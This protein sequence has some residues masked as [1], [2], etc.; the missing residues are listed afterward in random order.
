MKKFCFVLVFIAL[1]FSGFAG[2]CGEPEANFKFPNEERLDLAMKQ[3]GVSVTYKKS[4]DLFWVS[5][6]KNMMPILEFYGDIKKGANAILNGQS[7]YTIKMSLRKGDIE[8]AL[9]RFEKY[10]SPVEVDAFP[11]VLTSHQVVLNQERLFDYTSA[12]LAMPLESEVAHLKN[13]SKDELVKRSKAGD[14]QA[15]CACFLFMQSPSNSP[16]ESSDVV[17]ITRAILK[18][19]N[20]LL[21]MPFLKVIFMLYVTKDDSLLPEIIKGNE[22]CILNS[23]TSIDADFA[24]AV[25]FS[26]LQSGAPDELLKRYEAFFAELYSFE[27]IDVLEISSSILYSFNHDFIKKLGE[28]ARARKFIADILD[29]QISLSENPEYSKTQQYYIRDVMQPILLA[30]NMSDKMLELDK[31][32]KISKANLKALTL[33]FYKNRDKFMKNLSPDDEAFIEKRIPELR[34]EIVKLCEANDFDGVYILFLEYDRWKNAEFKKFILLEFVEL[35]KAMEAFEESKDEL[36]KDF[37]EE[38]NKKL[39]SKFSRDKII[40]RRLESSISHDLFFELLSKLDDKDTR[41]AL[42]S[43]LENKVDSCLKM[44]YAKGVSKDLLFSDLRSDSYMF[45]YAVYSCK[46]GCLLDKSDKKAVELIKSMNNY[47]SPFSDYFSMVY[48]VLNGD[49]T[50]P[51][52]EMRI[53]LEKNDEV[54]KLL[55]DEILAHTKSDIRDKV[56]ILLNRGDEKAAVKAL[57]GMRISRDSFDNYS[58]FRALKKLKKYMSREELLQAGEVFKRLKFK[59]DDDTKDKAE[60]LQNLIDVYHEDYALMFEFLQKNKEFFKPY[61]LEIMAAFA[62][63]GQ[64]TDKDEALSKSL[65]ERVNKEA[66]ADEIMYLLKRVYPEYKV[67]QSDNT[68]KSELMNLG[69][70][71]DSKSGEALYYFASE[72]AKDRKNPEKV[73]KAAELYLKAIDCSDFEESNS[74]YVYRYFALPE[75]CYDPKVAF[76]IASKLTERFDSEEMRE[77]LATHYLT[78]LGVEKDEKKA[79]EILKDIVRKNPGSMAAVVLAYCKEK[80]IAGESLKEGEKYELL[81]KVRD[82]NLSD[83]AHSFC[84]RESRLKNRTPVDRQYAFEMLEYCISKN[85]YPKDLLWTIYGFRCE[86]RQYTDPEY[87]D[88]KVAWQTLMRI[89]KLDP[90]S[91]RLKFQEALHL[92]VGAGVEANPEVAAKTLSEIADSKK[93]HWQGAALVLCYAYEK[94]IGVKANPELAAKYFKICTESDV[95]F[96]C[97]GNIIRYAEVMPYDKEWFESFRDRFYKALESN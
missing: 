60:F 23:L 36:G 26:L 97:Y 68:R 1:I 10:A 39:S 61:S 89:K 70:G 19:D 72:L 12:L 21:K 6:S 51:N 46:T 86:N 17:E 59:R 76:E 41:S 2:M 13:L 50:L 85:I 18:S 83:A 8:K 28:N 71:K 52:T 40:L 33:Y 64:G 80:G 15:I 56:D 87:R 31:A 73:K 5:V 35:P 14:L 88:I 20:N 66:S 93:D 96:T 77:R 9:K 78:G 58:A 38:F 95:T 11:V 62:R 48:R 81:S 4:G 22:T 45:A 16:L 7:T 54:M 92:L 75:P 3:K 65:Y 29:Y 74:A 44:S 90:N 49:Y 53:K 67:L 32:G 84:S 42:K 37:E 79:L 43:F 94:G 57:L 34:A 91:E 24:A 47:N 27:G 69:L 25:Y 30:M 55:E 82:Y 63:A